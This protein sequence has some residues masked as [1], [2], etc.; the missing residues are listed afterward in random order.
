MSNLNIR[1]A[2]EADI[3]SLIRICTRFYGETQYPAMIPL[4]EDSLTEM[5]FRVL[6]HG[7]HVVAEVNGEVI[8]GIGCI[9]QPFSMNAAYKVATEMFWY[10]EPE[11]RNQASIGVSLCEVA[12]TLA[13]HDGCTLIAMSRLETSPEGVD[14]FY[15]HRGYKAIDHTYVKGI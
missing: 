4:D 14:K 5:I 13:R 7:F 1:L 8:G 3:E 15:K 12:E 9:V 6:D 11:Y 10:V 2:T